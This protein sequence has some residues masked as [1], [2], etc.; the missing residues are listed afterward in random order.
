MKIAIPGGT[1]QV[2][3]L[4]ACAFHK[5]GSSAHFADAG[6]ISGNWCAKSSTT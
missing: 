6:T 4:L 1:G 3:T 5:D 2:T